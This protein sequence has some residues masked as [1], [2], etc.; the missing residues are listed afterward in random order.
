[1]R[2]RSASIVAG[3]AA[4]APTGG[5]VAI[6]ATDPYVG[7]LRTFSRTGC[8]AD[9]QGVGTFTQSMTSSC[10]VYATEFNSLYIHLNPGWIFRAHN[11]P[12]CH[13]AG[14]VIAETTAGSSP[15]VCNNQTSPNWVAYSVR[16]IQPGD[17]G[18]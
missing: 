2:T 12:D 8:S 9:N 4:L 13:D 17:P 18:T 6:P 15:V 10:Q 1:M 3:I 11:T 7:D 16:P 5:S 14:I